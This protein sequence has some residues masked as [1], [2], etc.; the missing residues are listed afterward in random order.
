MTEFSLKDLVKIKNGRDHKSLP[1][2]PIPVLGSGGVMRYVDQYL[3]DRESI[4]LPRKG[5]LSNIQFASK[6]FWT[7]DT[8]YYTE[9]DKTKCEPFYLYNYLKLLDLSGLNS[10]TGVPSMT[11]GA[12]Y[13]IK[14][15]LPSLSTQK[16]IANVL[17][18]LDAKIELNNQINTEL[19]AMAKL[20]YDYWFVQFDFPDKN[21]EPY[22]SNGGKMVYN[23]VLKRE[24]PERWEVDRLMSLTSKI[25]DGIHGTPK[26]V[27][28]SEYTFINGNNLKNG[29]IRMDDGAK[30][31]SF[32]EYQK[33]SKGLNDNTLLMSINGTLGN[34]AIYNNEKVMLGKSSAY[35]NC[36]ENHRSYCYEYLNQDHMSKVFWNIAT[37][38]TIKNLSLNSIKNLN[39]LKPNSQL[40]LDYSQITEPLIERRKNL[41]KENQELASLRDW[42]L[43]ML[44]N[45][46][47]S[48]REG[49][50]MVEDELGMVAE[51]SSQY[52][53]NNLRNIFKPELAFDQEIAAICYLTK[54][55]L[56]LSYGKK[57]YHKTL[58]NIHFLENVER[59][60]KI[61]FKE[62]YW[63]MYSD[64]IQTHLQHSK[65]VKAMPSIANPTRKVYI[66]SKGEKVK[67]KNWVVQPKN[68]DFVFGLSKILDLY[69]QS[70]IN[71]NMDQI[72]LL[73][74]VLQCITITESFD[75]NIIYE[76]M[77]RWQVKEGA[78]K[79]KAEKFGRNDAK[80]IIE[81]IKTIY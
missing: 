73:N 9:V 72:E 44:M 54:E 14:V 17:S 74:T 51:V 39:I 16:K 68:K 45:G 41:F 18:D 80:K 56:G 48:V 61:T 13:N 12:Y 52:D 27:A 50:N 10:G 5:S 46:Q 32:E 19:E 35:I 3:Y 78:F 62:H 42:L 20:V 77:K 4:L 6:P 43:P 30:K 22:K 15:K 63:G 40:I 29:F 59:L 71:C 34:L 49:Y 2:G 60:N 66:L 25:G 33:H 69:Q 31:V 57:Y 70:P 47:V 58:S 28:H 11:F 65:K 1:E 36:L 24:I 81:M 37:G 79:N 38:S 23:E 75:F 7:V 26:Y 67:T 55:R 8:L 53:I 21:G 76:K 64:L